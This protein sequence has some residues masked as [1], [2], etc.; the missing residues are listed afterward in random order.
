MR[1]SIRDHVRPTL[2]ETATDAI[3]DQGV[4]G[5]ETAQVHAA[6]PAAVGVSQHHNNAGFLFLA[7]SGEYMKRAG[8]F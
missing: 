1:A 3:A 4:E 7:L 8:T 6:E 2:C 5:W